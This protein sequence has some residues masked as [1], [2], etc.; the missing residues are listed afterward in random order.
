MPTSRLI[1]WSI[2]DGI[3]PP[4]AYPGRRPLVLN[5]DRFLAKPI[6][7]FNETIITV[8]DAIRFEANVKG[9]VHVGNVNTN[10]PNEAAM[11]GSMLRWAG[12]RPTL[13]QLIPIAYVVIRSLD[14]LYNAIIS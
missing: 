11:E 8:R 12:H 2:L 5:L 14:P 9:G 3:Y 4:T 13:R 6:A 10:D 1:V 7:K